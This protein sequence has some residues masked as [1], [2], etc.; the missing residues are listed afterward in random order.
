MR[1]SGTLARETW[2]T[3]STGTGEPAGTTI[4]SV[5]AGVT[6]QEECAGCPGIRLH[7]SLVQHCSGVVGCKSCAQHAKWLENS[8]SKERTASNPRCVGLGTTPIVQPVGTRA[9]TILRVGIRGVKK[10]CRAIWRSEIADTP[11][12]C[13][14]GDR[15]SSPV[16]TPKASTVVARALAP[17][18]PGLI[19]ALNS[20]A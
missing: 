17:A 5:L 12:C 19:Q 11:R 9:A 10:S 2:T 1:T 16:Q 20:P 15:F 14:T 13:G 8:S 4:R 6:R 18:A 3:W 7:P